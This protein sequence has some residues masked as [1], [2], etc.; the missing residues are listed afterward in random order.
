MG[1][2]ADTSKTQIFM[3]Q[4]LVNPRAGRDDATIGSGGN[5]AGG[6]KVVKLD[7]RDPRSIIPAT[8]AARSDAITAKPEARPAAKTPKAKPGPSP[9]TMDIIRA[10]IPKTVDEFV[11]GII[12]NS[13]NTNPKVVK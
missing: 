10:Q 3:G 8:L 2:V 12:F 7:M 1:G 13:G 6:R 4:T 5:L 11:S 9:E